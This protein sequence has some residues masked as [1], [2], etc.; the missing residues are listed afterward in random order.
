MI[1]S[2]IDR[3]QITAA[4]YCQIDPDKLKSHGFDMVRLRNKAGQ[5]IDV[6]VIQTK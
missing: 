5:L 2:V 6:L 4:L 3:S 1:D